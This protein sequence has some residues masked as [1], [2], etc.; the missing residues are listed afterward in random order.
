[1]HNGTRSHH[2]M[3]WV[4][5]IDLKEKGSLVILDHMGGGGKGLSSR[6]GAKV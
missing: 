1:M 3:A 6:I 4:L 5:S 2:G